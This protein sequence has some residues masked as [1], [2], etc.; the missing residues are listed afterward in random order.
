MGTSGLLIFRD[1]AALHHLMASRSWRAC[2]IFVAAA[3]KYS[4][5]WPAF[6]RA[7]I[8]ARHSV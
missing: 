8:C 4:G 5:V 2:S 7:S 1:G 3:W 6:I